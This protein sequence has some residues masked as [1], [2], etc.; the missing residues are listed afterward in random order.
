ML[1]QIIERK[2][3]FNFVNQCEDKNNIR[4]KLFNFVALMIAGYQT[5]PASDFGWPKHF[6]GI[7]TI[8]RLD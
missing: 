7:L 3:L 2:Y 8:K 6:G 4:A 5:T 1:I